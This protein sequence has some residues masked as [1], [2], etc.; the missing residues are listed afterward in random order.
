MY[1]LDGASMFPYN[2]EKEVMRMKKKIL[3]LL[4]AAWLLIGGAAAEIGDIAKIE[5]YY[6]RQNKL[7]SKSGYAETCVLVDERLLIQG[8]TLYV[9]ETATP[10][11]VKAMTMAVC[12]REEVRALGKLDALATLEA[13]VYDTAP[14]GE[15]AVRVHNPKFENVIVKPGESIKVPFSVII[16]KNS[17]DEVVVL[18]QEHSIIQ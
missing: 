18:F 5:T 17:A 3:M 1:N 6:D 4:V 15:W 16:N 2:A 12:T 8:G 13:I 10:L 14:V 9:N 11:C 7:T